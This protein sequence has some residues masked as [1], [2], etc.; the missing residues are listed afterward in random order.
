MDKNRSTLVA[1]VF[2]RYCFAKQSLDVQASLA[3]AGGY[4]SSTSR[5]G[6][7][8]SGLFQRIAPETPNKL[9]KSCL[10]RHIAVHTADYT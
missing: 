6:H 3:G 9:G 8:F 5:D 1:P 4:P 7:D 2:A 10:F